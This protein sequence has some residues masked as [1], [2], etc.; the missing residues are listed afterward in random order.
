M[1]EIVIGVIGVLLILYLFASI[2]KP[3]KF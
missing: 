3:E 1:L 2:I